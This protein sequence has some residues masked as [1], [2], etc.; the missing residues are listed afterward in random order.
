M[1][2]E[3]EPVPRCEYSKD[4]IKTILASISEA[5]IA[6][7]STKQSIDFDIA[8]KGLKPNTYDDLLAVLENFCDLKQLEETVSEANLLAIALQNFYDTIERL[9]YIP[10]HGETC[11]K[12]IEE[13]CIKKM[14]ASADAAAQ[15]MDVSKRTFYRRQDEAFENLYIIWFQMSPIYMH[16]VSGKIYEQLSF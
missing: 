15:A 3:N 8:V 6:Y 12:I 14:Y 1:N 5:Q 11:Y 2:K 13:Y 9:K 10:G 16:I 4:T 7:D